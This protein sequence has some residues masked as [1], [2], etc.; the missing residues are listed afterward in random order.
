MYCCLICCKNLKLKILRA[1]TNLCEYLVPNVLNMITINVLHAG[2]PSPT[3]RPVCNAKKLL[4]LGAIE[5]EKFLDNSCFCRRNLC[6][7]K[8][9]YEINGEQQARLMTALW[10]C[11]LGVFLSNINQATS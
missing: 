10:T 8:Y 7:K 9:L 2:K 3:S 6:D 11:I 1:P 5:S 4:S